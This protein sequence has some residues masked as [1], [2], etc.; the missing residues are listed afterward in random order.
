MS[1]RWIKSLLVAAVA[2][3]SPLFPQFSR[4]AAP[5]APAKR[6]NV[7]WIVA[8]DLGYADIGAQAISKD[9]ATPNIDSIAKDGVRFT[10][11]YVSCPVCSPSRAGFLTGRY[12]ERFGY[13]ANPLPEYDKTFGLPVDQ[14]TIADE[15]RRLG[16]ATG[17]FGKWHQG[18][19]EKFWPLKRGFDEFFGFLGGLHFYAGNRTIA[20][21]GVNVIR[22]GNEP[23][24]EKEYLTDAITREA[25]S[26]IDRHKDKPFFAYV[27]YN[28]VHT[29]QQAPPRYLKRFPESIDKQRRFMLA[30]LA[31]EDDGVGKI[32]AKLR[33][34][35]LEENTLVVFLSDNGG[36]T[37]SNASRN[38]PLRGFKGQV[39]EG[40]IRVA[41]MMKWPGHIKPGTVVEHPVISLDLF[42]TS[43]AA[44]GGEPRKETKLDGVNLLPLLEGKTDA[45]PHDTLYWRFRP[46]WAIRDG[47][48]K[49]LQGRD[50]VTHLYDLARD[51]SEQTDL[52]KDQ[53]DVVKKLQTKFDAWNA[54]LM[55]PLWPGR[56]EGAEDAARIDAEEAT[57]DAD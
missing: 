3:G 18:D 28:A 23:V 40:G 2:V 51:A 43:I 20:E 5:E 9:V 19:N 14:V 57:A 46:Q 27:P 30:M 44:A 10:N 54:E 15:M 26:F 39:W 13:E 29:P 48:Y 38:T 42:P 47:N 34:E 12:Q 24:L 25:V 56:Q 11:G 31:A 1:R 50:G 32:L 33:E 17:A 4:A 49:L 37:S 35:K 53:P 16:Y 41:F 8:D 6:A 22:R 36:P 7:I 45:A 55:E 21:Q 52:I